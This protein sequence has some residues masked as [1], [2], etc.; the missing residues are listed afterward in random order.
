MPQKKPKVMLRSLDPQ[1]LRDLR[2]L[3]GTSCELQQVQDLKSMQSVC[4]N[5]EIPLALIVEPKST[6]ATNPNAK[7]D[8]IKMLIAA[9]HCYPSLR[10]VVIVDPDD[11]SSAIEGL[12]TGAIDHLLYRP[13]DNAGVCSALRL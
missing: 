2:Q 8:L 12:H 13:F 5:G 7:E 6:A 11:L 9:R 10:R 3:L 1:T 4:Q